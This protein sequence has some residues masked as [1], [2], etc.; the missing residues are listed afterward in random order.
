[1]F[2]Y[3]DEKL[4][5]KADNL[6]QFNPSLQFMMPMMIPSPGMDMNQMQQSM[7]NGQLMMRMG[8]NMNPN[9]RQ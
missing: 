4:R 6:Y 9:M 8:M 7:A 1:M 2:V 5:N 3:C